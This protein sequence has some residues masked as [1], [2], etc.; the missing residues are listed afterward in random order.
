MPRKTKKPAKPFPDSHL[1][2]H[3]SGQWAKKIL[4]R[5]VYFGK[6][7]LAGA[8]MAFATGTKSDA[9]TGVARR[10]TVIGRIGRLD[11]E[12]EWL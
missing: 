4:G 2:L 3:G 11:M 12:L 8:A 5:T 7:L 1:F 9:G 10:G 6:Q